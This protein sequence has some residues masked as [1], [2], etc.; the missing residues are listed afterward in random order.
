MQDKE[1]FNNEEFEGE[2]QNS[3]DFCPPQKVDDEPILSKY[4]S[5]NQ[6]PS[7]HGGMT[8]STDIPLRQ[9]LIQY[10]QNQMQHHRIRTNVT[11]PMTN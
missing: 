5:V 10:Q 2:E 11:N 1:Y 3:P 6:D 7:L 8:L 4:R 9:Q